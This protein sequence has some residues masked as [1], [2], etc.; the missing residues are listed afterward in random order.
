[1]REEVVGKVV[2]ER[3]LTGVRASDS[4]YHA[5]RSFLLRSWQ[6]DGDCLAGV[7]VHRLVTDSDL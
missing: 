6:D 7:G 2:W 4:S 3:I 5:V 1:M